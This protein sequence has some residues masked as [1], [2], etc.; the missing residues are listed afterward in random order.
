VHVQLLVQ[1]VIIVTLR[2]WLVCT[3]I[4]IKTL[5]LFV[6]IVLEIISREFIDALPQGLLYADNMITLPLRGAKYC[7]EYVCYV[8]LFVCS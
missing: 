5:L 8:C 3:R 2:Q 1:S 7:D 4:I 6:Q